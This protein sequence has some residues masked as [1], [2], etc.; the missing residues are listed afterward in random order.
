MKK[1]WRGF[2]MIEVALFLVITGALFIAVTAGVQNS[3]AQQ[4]YNDT[5]QNFVEFLR[6]VYAETMNVQNADNG[7][8]EQAIYGKLVTFGEKLNSDGKDSDGNVAYVYDVVG[9]V[10]GE[11]GNKVKDAL[12]NLNAN[13]IVKDGNSAVP[14]GIVENYTPRWTGGLEPVCGDLSCDDSYHSIKAALLVVRHPRSGTVYTYVMNNETVEV[15]QAL[16]SINDS[17]KAGGNADTLIADRNPLTPFLGDS[18]GFE[19]NDLDFC[20]NPYAGEKST[21]RIDVR[22]PKNA[23]NSS[24]IQTI[25]DFSEA[26]GNRCVRD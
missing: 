18:G 15:N 10:D 17:I 7:R 5:V 8:S 14:A 22:I 11:V 9:K 26:G 12:K 4:R 3:I 2:T 13:V 1:F 23:R 16:K 20:I 25:G 21:T 6:S 19:I 24:A